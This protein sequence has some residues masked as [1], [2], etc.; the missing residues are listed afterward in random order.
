M[1][2]T[3]FD[4]PENEKDIRNDIKCLGCGIEKNKGLVLCW[5]CYKYRS[6][7]TPFKN[8]K[9]TIQEWLKLIK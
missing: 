4:I 2:L 6:D 1:D 5:N 7:I 9:G 8:F 3:I